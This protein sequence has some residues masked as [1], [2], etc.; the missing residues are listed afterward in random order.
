MAAE[1]YPVCLLGGLAAS[2]QLPGCLLYSAHSNSPMQQGNPRC[3]QCCS[4]GNAATAQSGADRLQ[5]SIERLESVADGVLALKV[6]NESYCGDTNLV[7]SPAA[8]TLIDSIL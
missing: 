5:W 7:A 3:L 1:A 2:S 4:E 6:S 8:E